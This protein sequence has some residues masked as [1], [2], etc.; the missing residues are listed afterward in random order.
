MAKFVLAKRYL[1]TV[2]PSLVEAKSLS[3][4]IFQDSCKQK[5]IL[6]DLTRK[7]L[8]CKILAERQNT[9]KKHW[10]TKVWPKKNAEKV[11]NDSVDI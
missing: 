6:Q 8:S 10:I 5:F 3:C 9:L 2:L 11:Y 7:S 1:V 4:K